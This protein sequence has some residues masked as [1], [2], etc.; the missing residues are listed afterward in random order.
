MP[1]RGPS[2]GFPPPGRP[3]GPPPGGVPSGPVGPG[4][5]RGGRRPGK[6]FIGAAALGAI[7]AGIIAFVGTGVATTQRLDNPFAESIGLS[8]WPWYGYNDVGPIY[9]LFAIAMIGVVVVGFVLLM[10]ATRPVPGGRAWP[11]VFLAAWWAIGIAAVI[12]SVIS[13]EVADLDRMQGQ[14]RAYQA[15]VTAV[16]WTLVTGWIP[17]VFT[18]TANA[19]RRG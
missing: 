13:V 4:D 8:V 14:H 15:C 11:T 1:P 12:A 5:P 16:M 6:G 2:Q 19:M 18:A 10:I 9:Q 17:A 3:P 7:V